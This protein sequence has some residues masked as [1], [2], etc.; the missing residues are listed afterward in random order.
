MEN[1]SLFNHC[2]KKY[3][4][5]VNNSGC[6]NV[7]GILTMRNKIPNYEAGF[8]HCLNQELSL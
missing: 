8:L 4:L 6:D 3:K 1:N 5:W 2:I 7:D